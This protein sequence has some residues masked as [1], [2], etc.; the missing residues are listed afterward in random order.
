MRQIKHPF[1]QA[2]YELDDDFNVKVS[3]GDRI[4]I[5]DPEGRY[6][7]GTI[8][9]CDPELARWVGLGPR[10]RGD[11]SQ[12]RRY[13]NATETIQQKLADMAAGKAAANGG[14]AL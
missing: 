12:N 8:R 6:L 13:M 14:A 1:S 7:H 11:I 2:I 10:E 9:S 5:F 4:G 3:L